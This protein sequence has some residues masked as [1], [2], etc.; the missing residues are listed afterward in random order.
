MVRLLAIPVAAVFAIA[1]SPLGSIE[2]FF[3]GYGV[4]GAMFLLVMLGWLRPRWAFDEAAK[5]EAAKDELI[6]SMAASLKS[7]SENYDK[8]LA[9]R[10][11]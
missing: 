4:L 5:R 6:A 1:D 3:L 11:S 10:R 8:V 9:R 7:L 2:P